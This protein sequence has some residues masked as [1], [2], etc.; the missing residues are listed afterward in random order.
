MT[1][2]DLLYTAKPNCIELRP[3]VEAI[4]D[5]LDLK[6]TDVHELQIQPD[7]ITALIFLQNEEGNKY[8]DKRSRLAVMGRV[9]RPIRT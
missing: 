2:A 4:C 5:K 9:T 7:E 3:E 6:P 1:K 8:V